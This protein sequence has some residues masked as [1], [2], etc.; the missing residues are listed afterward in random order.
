[1]RVTLERVVPKIAPE[2][3]FAVYPQFYKANSLALLQQR[4]R[5][6]G[7]WQPESIRIL[8]LL[9]RDD[10]DC[11]QLKRD[12]E[13]VAQAAGLATRSKPRGQH[14][15]VVNRIVIEELEAWFFGDWPAVMAAYPR[16]P[17]T[18]P[19]MAAYR[20]PDGI[21][22]GTWEALERVLQRARYFPHGLRKVE[23]ARAIAEHMRPQEN[24]SASFRAFRDA[25]R[26]VAAMRG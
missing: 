3:S 24:R 17:R 4:L 6:Y 10:D 13:R 19:Q 2:L 7:R 22:G 14:F 23:A 12:M 26:E 1:M 11:H 18:V 9:D 5:G 21:T 25:V 16:V 15:A 8:V 20:D